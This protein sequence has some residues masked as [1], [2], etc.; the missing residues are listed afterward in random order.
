MKCPHCKKEIKQELAY[1]IREENKRFYVY[2]FQ[3][4]PV[5]TLFDIKSTYEEAEQAV[6]EHK[7]G[8]HS[9]Q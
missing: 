5:E 4:A 3:V 2:Y 8:R 6:T 7:K 9:T 1:F